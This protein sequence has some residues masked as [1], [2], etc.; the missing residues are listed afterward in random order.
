MAPQKKKRTAQDDDD[1]GSDTPPSPLRG[2]G[3]ARARAT[4]AV[5][6]AR[7]APAPAHDAP[8]RMPRVLTRNKAAATG[9]RP[10]TPQPDRPRRRRQQDASPA[11][12]PPPPPRGATAAR[13]RGARGGARGGARPG[14]LRSSSPV[15]PAIKTVRPLARGAGRKS[16]RFLQRRQTVNVI[17][18]EPEQGSD[19]EEPWHGIPPEDLED[20]HQVDFEPFFDPEHDVVPDRV[21]REQERALRHYAPVDY[22][23]RE[24]VRPRS[25]FYSA[26]GPSTYHDD[27]DDAR[28]RGK[29][30]YHNVLGFAPLVFL[31]HLAVLVRYAA[32]LSTILFA[33]ARLAASRALARFAASLYSPRSARLAATCS[34]TR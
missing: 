23:A 19:G 6:G 4:K 28:T 22:D 2:R 29:S 33:L 12:E 13:G 26:P 18:L 24:P 20:D 8:E 21:R 15:L 7:Q 14:I 10:L 3:G 32:S 25:N 30:F 31:P 17:D 9:E 34:P 16:H 1:E 27:R 11:Q 5:R